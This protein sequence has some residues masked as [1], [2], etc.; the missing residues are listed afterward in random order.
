MYGEF[1]DF[2]LNFLTLLYY[3]DKPDF[4][5]KE[6]CKFRGSFWTM[7]NNIIITLN[8]YSCTIQFLDE[9]SNLKAE[10]KKDVVHGAFDAIYVS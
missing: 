3:A 8:M 6:F 10:C 2:F 1:L 7:H 9:S 5:C 4:F